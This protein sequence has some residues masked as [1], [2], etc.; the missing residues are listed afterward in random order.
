MHTQ[1]RILTMVFRPGLFKQ[2]YPIQVTDQITKP[3]LSTTTTTKT[4]PRKCEQHIVRFN[5]DYLHIAL[6]ITSK[7]FW[8]SHK[9][10]QCMHT[11]TCI[12]AMV[13]RPGLFKELVK[14][15]VQVF[16]VGPRFDQGRTEVRPRSNLDDVI[17]TL[18]IN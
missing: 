17:I 3:I 1:T 5:L 4:K 9:S 11:Q 7:K 12:L 10:I 8:E 2:V 18:I 16:K 14:G 6:Q 13:F 15:D